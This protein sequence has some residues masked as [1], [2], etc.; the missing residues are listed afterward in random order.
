[1]SLRPALF[2][3]PC[4]LISPDRLLQ[5]QEHHGLPTSASEWL[6]QVEFPLSCNQAA[7]QLFERGLALLHS[8]WWS[9][10]G[11][12]FAAVAEA[13]PTCAMAY[14]GTALVHRGNWFAGAPG[15]ES[16]R[17]GLAATQQG[18]AL[19]APTA[20]ER[21]YLAAA[22]ALFIDHQAAD[23]RTRSLAY[24]D[25]MLRLHERYPDDAEA[26]VFYALALTSNA[27]PGDKTFERQLLAGAIL[28]AR[29]QQHPDHPG[30]T[31]Y[32]I[33][34]YDAPPIAHLGV[35]AARRYEAIAPSVPHAQHMP[36]H[37]F[38]RLGL[39]EESIRANAASAASARAYEIAENMESVSFDRAHAWDYLVYAYLQLGRDRLA[40]E[41]LKQVQSASA[42]SSIATDYAFAAIPARIH[43]ERDRWSDAAIL[44][45]RPS[46]GFPAGEAITHFARGLGAARSGDAGAAQREVAA[47]ADLRD[48]LAGRG[49]SYWTQIVEAQRLTVDA[50]IRLS[51][52]STSDALDLITRAAA[53]EE[54]VDK[55]PVTPGP[56]LSARELQGDMLLQLNRPLE[57]LRAYEASLALDPKRARAL[58]YAARAAE[59]VGQNDRAADHYGTY[60]QLMRTADGDVSRR[61]AA[62]RFLAVHQTEP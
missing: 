54:R 56:I 34:T 19:G 4:L 59:R 12:T 26:A 17:R 37:I 50:W 39:W 25:A 14:W 28:E 58:F 49:E 40:D 15:A 20:R 6:G 33:H 47:L 2:L 10:A 32:L 52:E 13:D 7:Q 44:P 18:I 61:E 5:A 9:E 31:H 60:L 45:V 42:S 23:H 21:E 53:I 43:L 27:L 35:E 41:V 24:E 11:R 3:I 48:Q 30:V 55:H 62:S 36:S 1:M 8:F 46:P 57:A 38:T 29:F 51:Q 22:G 16:L